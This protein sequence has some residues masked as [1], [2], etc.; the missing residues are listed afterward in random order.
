MSA[1]AKAKTKA[2][3]KTK[4]SKKEAWKQAKQPWKNPLAPF[5]RVLEANRKALQAALPETAKDLTPERIIK[6]MLTAV[7]RTPA[8]LQCTTASILQVCIASASLALEPNSPL[9][10]LYAVPF[11][12]PRNGKTIW[13][14]RPI[15]G[16]RGLIELARRSG[17]VQTITAHVVH[18]H[19]EFD[20][21]F[22]M[23][24]KL[25]HKPKLTGERGNVVAA[26]CVTEFKDGSKQAEIMTRPEIDATRNR[27]QIKTA[28]SPWNTDFEEMARKSAVRRAAKY[29]PLTTELAQAIEFEN[30]FESG[31]SD[32]V[33]AVFSDEPAAI[34][35]PKTA[36]QELV[37]QIQGQP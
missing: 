29:W 9:G 32:A 2:T 7:G 12:T 21:E 23:T 31:V 30:A 36:T 18:E 28:D 24:P 14:A 3:T 15:I 8:L 20:V 4:Q 17:Q 10:H 22:G 1:A 6:S 5:R 25:V 19:D 33:G 34:E 26:Y 35:E 16:Y 11:E 13:E 37:Q 27:S